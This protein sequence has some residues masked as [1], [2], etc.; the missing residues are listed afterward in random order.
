[1]PRFVE[2]TLESLQDIEALDRFTGFL[3]GFFEAESRIPGP[4]ARATEEKEAFRSDGA[5][6]GHDLIIEAGI[7][8]HIRIAKPF[9]QHHGTT[10]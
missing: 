4:A 6:F 2:V 10:D 7:D 9:C 3:C 8:D 5:E 1:V